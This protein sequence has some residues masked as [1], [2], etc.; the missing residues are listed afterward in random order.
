MR[1]TAVNSVVEF[2]DVQSTS[3]WEKEI[4]KLEFCYQ[5]SLTTTLK[6]KL[7]FIKL[8]LINTLR[9]VTK[10]FRACSTKPLAP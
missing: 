5:F 6:N 7:W 1:E 10:A 4:R 8:W 9:I 2:M 3:D